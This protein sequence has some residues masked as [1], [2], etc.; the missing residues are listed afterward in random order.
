[1]EKARVATQQVCEKV[2]G[3][4]YKREAT[5][6]SEPSQPKKSRS[7]D[8]YQI[9]ENVLPPAKTLNN[10]KHKKALCQEILAA[11]ALATKKSTTKVKLHFDTTQRSRIDGDWPS[12]ILNLKDDNPLECPLFFAHEDRLQVISLIVET[13]NRLSVAASKL[14]LTAVNRYKEFKN[15]RGCVRKTSIKSYASPPSLQVQHVRT[16]R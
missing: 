9:Y 7:S 8:D 4:R 13:L 6:P 5:N 15:W 12:L 16:T 11:K 2:Y 1:M 14:N 3:H 10:F